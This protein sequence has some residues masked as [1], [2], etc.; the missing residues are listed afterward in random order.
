MGMTRHTSYHEE[1]PLR[2][3]F[4]LASGC[5]DAAALFGRCALAAIMRPLLATSSLP[6]LALPSVVASFCSR[7]RA[8]KGTSALLPVGQA[9]GAPALHVHPR[10]SCHSVGHLALVDLSKEPC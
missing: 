10:Q 5:L 7:G 1:L 6:R 3:P 4:K 8:N 2:V 9:T